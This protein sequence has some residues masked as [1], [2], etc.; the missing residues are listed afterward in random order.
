M[1]LRRLLGWSD[2]ELMRADAKPCST[3]MRQTAGLFTVCGGL[4]FWPL[5]EIHYGPRFTHARALR[6]I[7]CG[8]LAGCTGSALLVWL[9][10][11]ECEPQNI[12][13]YDKRLSKYLK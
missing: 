7:F 12:A 6:W 8:A 9:F 5:C 10:S 1:A 2:G 4:A 13:A 11:P 3:T